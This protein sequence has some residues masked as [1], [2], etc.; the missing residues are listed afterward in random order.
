MSDLKHQSLQ[1]LRRRKQRCE[2]TIS[3]LNGKLHNQH[4]RLTWINRYIEQKSKPR[5]MTVEQIE[6]RLGFKVSIKAAQ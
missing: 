1:E 3:E 2:Q 6:E 4:T 5:E